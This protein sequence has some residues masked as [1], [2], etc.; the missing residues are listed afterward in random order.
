MKNSYKKSKKNE[1]R[2]NSNLFLFIIFIVFFLLTVIFLSHGLKSLTT[3]TISKIS[4]RSSPIKFLS[5]KDRKF[6][7]LKQEEIKFNKTQK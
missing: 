4:K 7:K 1:E 5:R 3:K 6:I 2:S